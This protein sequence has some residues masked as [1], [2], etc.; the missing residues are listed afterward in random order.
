MLFSH[1]LRRLHR[2]ATLIRKELLLLLKE[3]PTRMIL[4]VPVLIQ[5]LV[6]PFAA[7]LN[8]TNA[9][10]GIYR[11]D[12]GAESEEIINRLMRVSAFSQ[13]KFFTS[14][15]QMTTA[16]ENQQVLL[17]INFPADFSKR[18]ISK[19]QPQLQIILDGRHSNSAQIAASYVQQI[20]QQYQQERACETARLCDQN[21]LVV[22]HWYNPNLDY[23][24]FVLPSLVALITTIGILIVT[25][26]SIARE[27]EQGTFEQLLVSPLTTWQ[28][29][30]GKAIPAL[31]VATLQGTVI[32]LV[33]IYG[34]QIAF[35]GSLLFYYFCIFSYCLSL[36]GIG[37]LISALC[38]TQQQ[39][40]IGIIIFMIP[41]ILLS[42]YISP[43]EN[44]PLMLQHLVAINP[45]K[46]FTELTKEIYLK[47]AAL[48]EL[49]QSLYPLFFIAISTMSLAYFIF[50]KRMS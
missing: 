24:W 18:V 9:S 36:V 50:S 15:Q 43:V 33:S 44:M 11:L 6:F 35:Q 20:I 45:V 49:W 28:I 14:R 30:I 41:A 48:V 32:L 2:I 7:T 23:K 47:D 3:K 16:I 22:R 13:I 8:V 29:F 1:Y 27:R 40:F 46:H 5:V 25:A 17:S 31:I 38:S 12:H 10:I 19:N 26:L 21:Q 42:G 4:I 34:Y 37:L 39:A